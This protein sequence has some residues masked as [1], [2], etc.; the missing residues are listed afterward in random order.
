MTS[1]TFRRLGVALAVAGLTL[2]GCTST[3]HS[4]RAPTSTTPPPSASAPAMD[5]TTPASF[6]PQNRVSAASQQKSRGVSYSRIPDDLTHPQQVAA[7][8]VIL[9][10]T[11]DCRIDGAPPDA[12]KRANPLATP[13][14]AHELSSQKH[15]APSPWWKEMCADDGFIAVLI[16][17]VLGGGSGQEPGSTPDR[18]PNMTVTVLFHR[19][20]K[21]DGRWFRDMR[22]HEWTVTF[23][24]TQVAAFGP[25]TIS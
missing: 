15:V 18:D 3:D 1:T 23:H 19:A 12:W 9:A 21:R 4:D 7:T 16:D 14:L 17:N 20:Y 13:D 5:T 8:F 24:N 25:D 11:A 22:L 6:P 2:S 10:A